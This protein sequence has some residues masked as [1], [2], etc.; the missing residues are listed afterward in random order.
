LKTDDLKQEVIDMYVATIMDEMNDSL[1]NKAT[2]SVMEA[3]IKTH[4]ARFYD[5]VVQV[6]KDWETND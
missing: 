6:H 3:F 5:D 2:Y 4:L 1:S